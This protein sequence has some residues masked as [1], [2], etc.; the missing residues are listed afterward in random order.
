MFAL[1][2]YRSRHLAYP[3]L[4]VIMLALAVPFESWFPIRVT[5]GKQEG[6]SG[7]P[8]YSAW[9]TISKIDVYKIGPG[10]RSRLL[11]PDSLRLIVFDQ[12]TATT[13]ILSLQPD[14]STY[15]KRLRQT[16]TLADTIRLFTGPAF[17]NHTAP[18]VFILGSGGG[19]EVMH[20]L[21]YRAALIDAVEI[22]PAV[23]R[24]VTQDMADYAGKLAGQ[25]GFA[26][27]PRTDAALSSEV[28]RFMISFSRSIPSAR[29]P[30]PLVR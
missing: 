8:I 28:G 16:A 19:E 13:E 5:D 23:N 25:P 6:F 10:E 3:A 24:L 17:I 22:N 26:S 1:P 14:V 11:Y 15:I 30:P 29:Q 21:Y 9:N 2:A 20:A 4:A 27:S 18:R 12:G 7:K